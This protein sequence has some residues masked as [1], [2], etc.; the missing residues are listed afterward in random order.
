MVREYQQKDLAIIISVIII[1]ILGVWFVFG[2]S[3][4]ETKEEKIVIKNSTDQEFEVIVEIADDPEERQKG[5]MG[6]D[7]LCEN[8]G[9]LFVY[10]KDVDNGFWMKDTQIPLSIAFIHKNGTINE[11]QQM[12]PNT[13]DSHKPD[14]FYRYALEVNQGYFQEN[15]IDAGDVVSIP[16]NIMK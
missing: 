13:L 3:G 6:R 8:C 4:G 1:L 11:I 2:G 7:S 5:L 15:Q 12:D 14:S 9:M 16:E 10:K